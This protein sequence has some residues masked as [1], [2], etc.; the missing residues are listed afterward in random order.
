MPSQS[1]SGHASRHR[2]PTGVLVGRGSRA[3]SNRGSQ[4]SVPYAVSGGTGSGVFGVASPSLP[5]ST[6][7]STSPSSRSTPSVHYAKEW[8]VEAHINGC[9]QRGAEV[10]T[11]LE[12]PWVARP[13]I[14]SSAVTRRWR[15]RHVLKHRDE[16]GERINNFVLRAFELA[17]L[18]KSRARSKSRLS[19]TWWTLRWCSACSG[20]GAPALADSDDGSGADG[21][22]QLSAGGGGRGGRGGRFG[23][24]AAAGIHPSRD[25]VPS[26]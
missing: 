23:A 11:D 18:W 13:R 16:Q 8:L 10:G 14:R 19:L 5:D 1:R 22:G 15:W 21:S 7:G 25:G 9:D 2:Q 20:A 17:L 12:V 6:S 3:H 4:S 26:H 24:G